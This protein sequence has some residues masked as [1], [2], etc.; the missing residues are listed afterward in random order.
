MLV[1]RIKPIH[2]VLAMVNRAELLLLIRDGTEVVATAVD[3]AVQADHQA[4]HVPQLHIIMGMM[5][6]EVSNSI[7]MTKSCISQFED[8]LDPVYTRP[9]YMSAVCACV[10]NN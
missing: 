3:P 5:I 4:V 9:L 7:H 1:D 8:K 10:P 6:A 2:K